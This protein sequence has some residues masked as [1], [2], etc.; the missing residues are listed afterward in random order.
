MSLTSRQI[1][2]LHLM[3]VETSYQSIGYYAKK[4]GVTDRTLREDLKAITELL[5]Q[6]GLELERKAGKGILLSEQARHS[7]YLIQ[8]LAED[9]VGYRTLAGRRRDIL[10]ELLIDSQHF[11]SIQKLSERYYV[12]RTSIVNDLRYIEEWLNDYGLSLSR[13]SAG[14][15]VSG[16]ESSIR[17][18][19][20]A[21]IDTDGQEQ[22]STSLS[23]ID[24]V[25]MNSLAKL[26]RLDDIRF[27]EQLLGDLEIR[28]GCTIGEPYYLN[29]MTH[30]L[31]CVERVSKGMRVED[32]D[33]E[34]TV[35]DNTQKAYDAA[36][37]MAQRIEQHFSIRL[38]STEIYYLYRYLTAF[39]FADRQEHRADPPRER[40]LSRD[41]G[42]DILHYLSLAVGTELILNEKLENELYLHLRSMINRV[43]YDIQV[44]N[45]LLNQLRTLYPE[46]LTLME[47]LVW[48]LA[49]KY[50]LGTISPDETAYIVM[51]C[52][53]ALERL[54][55]HPRIL[56]ICQSGYGTSQLLR[57][58]L[59]KAFPQWEIA[60]V[61]S[62]RALERMELKEFSFLVSTVPLSNLSIPYILISPLLSERDIR[63][64]QD[65]GLLE[66]QPAALDWRFPIKT[67]TSSHVLHITE[68]P[69]RWADWVSRLP[70]KADSC[71]RF[72]GGRLNIQ[73]CL[74]SVDPEL[75]VFYDRTQHSIQS[76]IH[77]GS[78]DKATELLAVYYSMV[79][80]D[81]DW[82]RLTRYVEMQDLL[83]TALSPSCIIPHM[84]A[85]D[86]S[87]VI[88]QMARLLK[89]QGMIRDESS[90]CQDIFRREA[91]GPTAIGDG[92]ALPHGQSDQSTG[93]TLAMA[94]LE[95]PVLWDTEDG[96]EIYVRIVVL[97]AI[98]ES[99]VRC[100]SSG[101][102]EALQ[103]ICSALSKPE[104]NEHL[105]T[106]DS[107]EQVLEQM[108]L[109]MQTHIEE[110]ENG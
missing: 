87:D 97:F 26:F 91:C 29:L 22:D 13:S 60:G 99:E 98:S 73:L 68:K 65:S 61:V 57:T 14:T 37:D 101:Y 4:L 103:A 102:I 15:R 35:D 100:K 31:I 62:A 64:I 48:L 10:Q 54:R 81:H 17:K 2:F 49:K 105:L 55:D 18:A 46:L 6:H 3:T 36:V 76:V 71:P 107:G 1:S 51:Y 11:L 72:Q 69:E 84:D 5:S 38:G 58:R 104:H 30:L 7:P 45:V 85:T 20:A 95:H 41:L 63:K 59:S 83:R 33:E 12:S 16:S 78:L 80:H 39:G 52:Q 77:T 70:L 56:V 92:I 34:M 47:G 106:A 108:I 40:D 79:Q 66:G 44:R 42:A 24:N 19:F 86:K 23:R 9:E 88:H 32:T 27:L 25:T 28:T 21:L 82:D 110:E 43:Q 94:L 90:F 109:E 67:G 75:L 50:H 96:I 74:E 89:E 93:L 53:V 8:Y